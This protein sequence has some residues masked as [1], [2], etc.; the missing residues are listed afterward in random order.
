MFNPEYA[1]F[2]LDKR[3][4]EDQAKFSEFRSADCLRLFKYQCSWNTGAVVSMMVLCAVKRNRERVVYF[5]I[6]LFPCLIGWLLDYYRKRLSVD[7]QMKLVIFMFTVHQV[8]IASCYELLR[9]LYEE[10]YV[11]AYILRLY[12]N[13]AIAV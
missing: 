7:K 3:N 11:I 10:S 5:L 6:D 9:S 8:Y 12:A 2:L 4:K 13:Y 1:S